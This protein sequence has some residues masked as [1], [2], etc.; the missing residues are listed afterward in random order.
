MKKKTNINDIWKDKNI[1]KEAKYIYTYIY[2]K[3]MNRLLIDINIG[4]IQRIVKIKNEGLRKN[5]ERL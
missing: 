3:G 1:P 2:S 4:E 5:L